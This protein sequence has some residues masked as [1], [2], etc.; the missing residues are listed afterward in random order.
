MTVTLIR[1]NM[2]FLIPSWSKF[3]GL[4]PESLGQYLNRDVL[5]IQSDPVVFF[6]GLECTI[7]TPLRKLHF[8]FGQGYYYVR[9]EIDKGIY[10]VD[11]RKLTGLILSD[12]AYNYLARSDDVVLENDC[13]CFVVR[14]LLMSYLQKIAQYRVLPIL[15]DEQENVLQFS[16]YSY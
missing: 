12:F 13:L 4:G 1:N 6:G 5:A 3:L 16:K 15:G 14:V 10:T 7:I 9:F 2:L 11:K 8:I